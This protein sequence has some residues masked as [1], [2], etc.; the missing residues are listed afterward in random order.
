VRV[1]APELT[2]AREVS[3]G[4]TARGE[5][6]R[7]VER[8][9]DRLRHALGNHGWTPKT[10]SCLRLTAPY[11][12]PG[13]IPRG[14]CSSTRAKEPAIPPLLLVEFD[15]VRHAGQVERASDDWGR[16]LDVHAD[17]VESSLGQNVDQAGIGELQPGQVKHGLVAV[18]SQRKP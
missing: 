12:R 1:P 14:S 16:V 11:R 17:A 2:T 15:E 6:I 5:R 4:T 8:V 9:F 10:R 3:P 18:G 7:A 13:A